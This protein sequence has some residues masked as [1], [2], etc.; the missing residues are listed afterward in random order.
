M[1]LT[2][3]DRSMLVLR[4]ETGPRVVR[5]LVLEGRQGSRSKWIGHWLIRLDALRGSIGWTTALILDGDPYP[6]SAPH[7][8]TLI[9][10]G[11]VVHRSPMFASNGVMP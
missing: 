2:A 4:R 7:I 3:A 5:D 6:G 11:A 1:A 9:D 10:Q 8:E